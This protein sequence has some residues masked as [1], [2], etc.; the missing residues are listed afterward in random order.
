MMILSITR[1][2]VQKLATALA[3]STGHIYVILTDGRTT[4]DPITEMKQLLESCKLEA[5]QFVKPVLDLWDKVEH[6][7]AEPVKL[8]PFRLPFRPFFDRRSDP[9]WGADCWKAKT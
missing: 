4:T 8:R 6:V 1:E 5:K 3:A 7:F 2:D 9:R